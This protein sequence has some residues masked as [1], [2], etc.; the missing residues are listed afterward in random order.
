MSLVWN[1]WALFSNLNN[2][3]VS[4][5]GVQLKERLALG[6]ATPFGGVGGGWGGYNESLASKTIKLSV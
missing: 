5:E 3:T 4:K 6:G 2:K 1:N